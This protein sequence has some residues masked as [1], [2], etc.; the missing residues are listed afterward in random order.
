MKEARLTPIKSL[1]LGLPI[2]LFLGALLSDL[3]Y[4]RSHEVQWVNFAAWLIAGAL[5]LGGIILLIAVIDF[6]RRREGGRAGLFLLLV[7]SMWILGLLNALIHARDGWA[8]MPTGLILSLVVA[9]LAIAAA[10]AGLAAPRRT[11]AN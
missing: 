5:L 10:W 8:S 2:A 6:F 9:I 3:A 7:A 4:Y 11:E 1:L